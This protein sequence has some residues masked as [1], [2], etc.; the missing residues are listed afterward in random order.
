MKLTNNTM[1]VL[2]N[3]STINQNIYVK[4]GNVIETVSKQKN[5]LARATVEENFPQEFGV[6]D[7]NNFLG[8]LTLSKDTLPEIDFEDQKIIIRNRVGKSSTT[9]HQSKKELLLLAPEKKVSMENAEMIFTIT[10]EDL[11]WCLKAASALNSTNIAFVSDGTNITVDVFNVKDDSSNVNTTTIAE[12]DGKIFKMI[13]AIENFKFILGS[14]DVTIHSRGIGHF[15]NKS[16]PIEYWV[17]TE[18]GS[19]YGA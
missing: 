8:V 10:E 4:T 7:L 1:N 5:I 3:F 12:G 11:D 18:P 2:K 15:K 17:T 9:Y 19:T 6:Y 14:Y 13:F 16:V